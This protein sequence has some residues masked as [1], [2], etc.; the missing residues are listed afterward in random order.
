M[1][2]DRFPLIIAT[3]PLLFIGSGAALANQVTPAVPE[4]PGWVALDHESGTTASTPGHGAALETIQTDLLGLVNAE[5]EQAGAPPLSLNSQLN[6]A[7]QRQAADLARQG[8]LSHGG[9]DGSTMQT[10]I[11]DTGYQWTAIGENIA[12]GQRDAEAVMESWMNSPGHRRNILNP[13]FSEMGIGYIEAAGAK[14]WVQVF[15]SPR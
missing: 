14:Y 4:G 1:N 9:S 10:R 3:L 11:E 12:M 2:T 7:A 8:R 6:Q 5:R 15:A 13:T